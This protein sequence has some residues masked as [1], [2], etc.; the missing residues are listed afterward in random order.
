MRRMTWDGGMNA[1]SGQF[2]VNAVA[3]VQD[4][5]NNGVVTVNSGGTL[6]NAIS[7]IVSG[8]GSRITVN[9]GGQLN[10][11]SDGSGSASTCKA[12]CW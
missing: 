5:T 9:P 4:W 6:N 1:T 3:N 2:V 11:N 7:D 12:A 8:G 10:A